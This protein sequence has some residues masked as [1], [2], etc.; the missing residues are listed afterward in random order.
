MLHGVK[1]S[2]K[3]QKLYDFKT[4][5]HKHSSSSPLLSSSLDVVKNLGRVFYPIGYGADP[6]GLQDSTATIMAAVT[7]AAMIEDGQHL[8]PGVNDLGGA[9]VDFQ[10]GSY[11]IS[12]PIVIPHNSGNLVVFY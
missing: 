6:G 1:C 3:Q 11:K 8:L 5:I 10:G 9:I 2:Q 4:K 12:K 7:D